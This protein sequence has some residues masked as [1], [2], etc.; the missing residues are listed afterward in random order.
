VR[1][2]RL[3]QYGAGLTSAP[4]DVQAFLDGLSNW[5]TAR[6]ARVET[7]AYGDHPDQVIDLRFPVGES[8]PLALVLHGGFWRPPYTRSSTDA[9]CVALAEAGW[10]T[11]N[12]EYRRTGPGGW[13]PMLADVASARRALDGFSPVI[14][15]GHSAG[16]H[17]ALWLA[18]EGAVDAAAAL[19]GACDLR[20]A[21]AERLGDGAAQELLG[22][23]PDAVPAAYAAADPAAR[24]PLGVPQLLV[25]GVADDR[26]PIEHAR[27]YAAQAT[28]AGDHCALLELSCDHFAPIDPRAAAWPAVLAALED[29]ARKAVG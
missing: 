9:L 16:G 27:A 29:C 5:A 28:A 2:A 14:A 21:A 7:L 1:A 6:S 19:G 8:L 15:I 3:S 24:L 25:H 10:A 11:A 23:E 4:T 12:V 22:G 18:A 26:V 13:E 17:L 20:R